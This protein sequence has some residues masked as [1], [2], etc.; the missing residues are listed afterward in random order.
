LQLVQHGKLNR[1]LIKI[2]K[3]IEKMQENDGPKAK[4][5]KKYAKIIRLIIYGA[6]IAC[7]Y[8]INRVLVAEST[9]FWPL[10]P[11]SPTIDIFPFHIICLS[12]F[13]WRHLFR[14][15]VPIFNR[16]VIIP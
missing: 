8:N 6:L 5:I 15:F 11:S 16:K 12:A 2:D 9:I 10:S 1:R 14:I 4:L 13:S 3:E 7:C